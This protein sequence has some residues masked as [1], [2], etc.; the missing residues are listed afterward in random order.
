MRYNLHQ[1]QDLTWE[2]ALSVARRWEAAHDAIG[3][4]DSNNGRVSDVDAANRKKIS[5]NLHW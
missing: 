2:N 4:D 1:E 3:N 5:P